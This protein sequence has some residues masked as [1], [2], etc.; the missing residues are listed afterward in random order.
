MVDT[1]MDGIAEK[2]PS[3]SVARFAEAVGKPFRHLVMGIGNGRVV[4][5]AA[6]DDRHPF[7]ILEKS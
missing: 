5:I 3:Q 4:E 6:Q 7:V 1:H 2:R